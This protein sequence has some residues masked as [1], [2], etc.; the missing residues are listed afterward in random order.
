MMQLCMSKIHTQT[1]PGS[2]WPSTQAMGEAG[3]LKLLQAQQLTRPCPASILAEA[4]CAGRLTALTESQGETM[5]AGQSSDKGIS[6]ERDVAVEN[7]MKEGAQALLEGDEV[8]TLDILLPDDDDV[9]RGRREE[10]IEQALKEIVK[11][12]YN[13][14][15]DVSKIGRSVYDYVREQ[16]E[17]KERLNNPYREIQ[18]RLKDAHDQLVEKGLQDD[19]DNLQKTISRLDGQLKTGQQPAEV[20]L[21]SSRID[22]NNHELNG[23]EKVMRKI[24]ETMGRI[25]KVG[26][27]FEPDTSMEQVRDRGGIIIRENGEY[28]EF[29]PRT[30]FIDSSEKIP[31]HRMGRYDY[32]VGPQAGDEVVAWEPSEEA[33]RI[34]TGVFGEEYRGANRHLGDTKLEYN[35]GDSSTDNVKLDVKSREEGR[36]HIMLEGSIKLRRTPYKK[37]PEREIW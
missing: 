5:E 36:G 23:P 34:I 37:P 19:A 21:W 15:Q 2:G 11:G 16:A 30:R 3:R 6:L 31:R 27:M 32:M 7:K 17:E 4:T 22:E 10:A 28:E 33:Q 13:R 14:D 9:Y 25:P 12:D 18:T 24:D 8:D 1:L 35:T 20:L 29:Y 26:W